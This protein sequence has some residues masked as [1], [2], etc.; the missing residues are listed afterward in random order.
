MQ[1]QLVLPRRAQKELA[2]IDKRYYA[3]IL[4]AL[5]YIASNP[6]DGKRLFGEH[7]GELSYRVWPYRIIYRIKRKDRVVLVVHVGHRQGVY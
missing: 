2:R 5:K 4:L 3:R 6:Y 7:K 1:H